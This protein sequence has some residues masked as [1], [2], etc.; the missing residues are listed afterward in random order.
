MYAFTCVPSAQIHSEDICATFSNSQVAPKDA[1]AAFDRCP[2]GSQACLR[3][4]S[5]CLIGFQMFACNVFV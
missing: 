2:S 3:S 1:C 4:V 5:E